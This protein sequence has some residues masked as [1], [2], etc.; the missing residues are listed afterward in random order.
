MVFPIKGIKMPRIDIK[1]IGVPNICFSLTDQGDN[2]EDIFSKQRRERGFDN[3]ELWSLD[4]TIAKFIYPRIKQFRKTTVGY[5]GGFESMEE[6]D[7]ILAKI[8]RAFFLVSQEENYSILCGKIAD[9][10][11]EGLNLFSEYFL[12]LWS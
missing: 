9:E 5:P 1:Y 2:R 12:N 4:A 11:E 8:E 3:S 7:A 6:W 10:I